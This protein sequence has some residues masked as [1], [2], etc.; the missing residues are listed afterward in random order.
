MSDVRA[1]FGTRDEATIR[2]T[3][4]DRWGAF[5]HENAIFLVTYPNGRV[6]ASLGQ[7]P[8]AAVAEEVP[9]VRDAEKAFPKQSAGFLYRG[10]SL[11]QVVITPVY[12]DS[13]P[14]RALLNVLLAAYRVDQ[15][16]V[17]RLRQATGGSDFVFAA[18]N[19]VVA[20]T[21]SRA[22]VGE[23]ASK[24]FAQTRSA[25]A[26]RVSF[27][28]IDY[29]TLRRPLLDVGG[30]PVGE[31]WILRS[32]E[33]E[34]QALLALRR[35][36]AFVWGGA[37]LAALALA[38][39]VAQHLMRPI[40]Q[41]DAAA[42]E[43][44]RQNYAHRVPVTTHDELGRLATAFNRM[45][46]S[47]QRA[48]ADLIRQE[49][50]TAVSRL[51]NS[52]V[53]DLRNPLAAIYAGSEMLTDGSLPQSGVRRLATNIHRASAQ[54]QKML[55]ELLTTG[56]GRGG[57]LES[58]EVLE[59]VEGAWE[60]V[61]SR[62]EAG[63]VTLEMRI[64]E[65]LAVMAEP[66]RMRR[67]FMNL[68]ANAIEAMPEGGR[69]TVY[70]SGSGGSALVQV[71]DEGCGISP[72]V[73]DRLFEPFASVKRNGMGLGLALARQTVAESGGDMWC[74]EGVEQGARFCL[75]LPLAQM[76]SPAGVDGD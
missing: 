43:V 17:T 54:I 36:L 62:A 16:E 46:E 34:R 12:V 2:D 23:C 19:Q 4:G 57:A 6:I 60:F 11:Y 63:G 45:C 3:A 15:N 75:R 14:D 47:L 20:S 70:A 29:L 71:Q 1:A 5:A 64:A 55:D 25:S 21:L 58:C 49:R 42:A 28:G 72:Q 59:L 44:S 50:L 66:R 52:L 38:W 48:R 18:G 26:Q 33:A 8:P 73:R 69:V 67:V 37:L 53:H 61:A 74:D 39:V 27:A 76:A 9:A 41:L 51:S 13:G 22:A 10:G 7:Q 35:D 65:G 40:A 24:L 56:R 32:F 30:R 31:V 68:F